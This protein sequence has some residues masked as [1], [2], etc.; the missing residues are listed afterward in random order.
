MSRRLLSLG[1]TLGVVAVCGSAGAVSAGAVSPALQTVQ[2][3]TLVG[4]ARLPSAA[5]LSPAAAHR[6]G[7]GPM[8]RM[9][10]TKR[11]A[12]ALSPHTGSTPVQGAPVV[13]GQLPGFIYEKSE[14]AE[15]DAAQ[16]S[17]TGGAVVHPNPGKPVHANWQ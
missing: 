2:R 5:G 11:G 14:S 8:R 1:C 15:K 17:I 9:P 4:S 10:N 7:A 16:R 3:V 13:G 6:S 12:T